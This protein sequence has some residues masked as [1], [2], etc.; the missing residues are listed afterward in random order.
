MNLALIALH[1]SAEP[2]ADLKSFKRYLWD[3]A[4]ANL[5]ATDIL[6]TRSLIAEAW[7]AYVLQSPGKF[8]L[9]NVLEQYCP[10]VTAQAPAQPNKPDITQTG[11]PGN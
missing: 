8:A 7:H 10:G 6:S 11:H 3:T 5:A 4:F 2:S 9:K 1:V